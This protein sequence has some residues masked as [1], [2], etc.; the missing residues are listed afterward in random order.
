M[1]NLT[2][3]AL[4]VC[5]TSIALSTADPITLG[6]SALASQLPDVDTSKSVIGR[7]LFPISNYIEARYP[8]RSITHSFLATAAIALLTLPLVIFNWSY[9]L[10]LTLGYTILQK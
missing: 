2:H 1:M 9:W 8:H 7:I 6:I 10:A 5:V 3:V 4:S